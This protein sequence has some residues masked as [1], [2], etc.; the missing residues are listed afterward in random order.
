MTLS[1]KANEDSKKF[2]ARFFGKN[3]IRIS[4]SING[5]C[6]FWG[7]S[8][9]GSWIISERFRQSYFFTK[10]SNLLVKNSRKTKIL[11][12]F[13]VEKT[14]KLL[15]CLCL[16]FRL[17]V[18]ERYLFLKKKSGIFRFRGNDILTSILSVLHPFLSLPNDDLRECLRKNRPVILDQK[19]NS[20]YIQGY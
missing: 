15:N 9:N 1:G 18:K 5:F 11:H 20:P 16:L 10:R 7:K 14:A 3:Q 8:K 6:V 19:I 4:E 2:R 12:S 17:K 13:S